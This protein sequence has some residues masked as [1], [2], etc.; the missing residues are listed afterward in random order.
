MLR[1][2]GWNKSLLAINLFL[3]SLAYA[4]VF[5]NLSYESSS[6]QFIKERS[7]YILGGDIMISSTSTPISQ[8]EL[9]SI[10]SLVKTEDS[11]SVEFLGNIRSKDSTTMSNVAAV[12]PN[13]PLLGTITLKDG[14]PYQWDSPDQIYLDKDIFNAL[15]VKVGDDVKIGE[16]QFK[17]AGE[18]LEDPGATRGTSFFA[19]RSYIP[20]NT[21]EQTGLITF[22]SQVS[23]RHF[24]ALSASTAEKTTALVENLKELSKNKSWEVRSAEDSINQIKRTLD[25]V[26]KYLSWLTLLMILLGFITGFYL[27]QVHLRS[28]ASRIA[29]LIQLG[30]PPR[31]V[32]V[33]YGLQIL[34]EH[35]VALIVAIGLVA[36]TQVL[37]IAPALTDLPIAFEFSLTGEALVITFGLALLM[38]F[39]FLVP[40]L[41]RVPQIQLKSLLDQSAPFIPEAAGFRTWLPYVFILLTFYALTGLFLRDYRLSLGWLGFLLLTLIVPILVFPFLLRKLG[42]KVSSITLKIPLLQLSRVRF[43]SSL[44]FVSL[45]QVLFILSLLPQ[46]K[47]SLEQELKQTAS[48][49][50]PDFFA[51]N[52]QEADLENIQ[53][54]FNSNSSGLKSLS[55]MILGRLMSV[56]SET[57]D[58]EDFSTRP[59]R[60]SYRA[61]NFPSE[62]VLE[63][64]E[65]LPAYTS[66]Q[67]PKGFLS[68]EKEYATRKNLKLG[69]SLKFLI[70]GLEI[71]AEIRQVR[72]VDWESFEPNFFMQFQDGFLNDFPKTW[73]GVIYDV[74]D[75]QKP[76]VIREALDEFSSMSIIDLSKTLEKLSEITETLAP[77]IQIAAQVQSGLTLL[78]LFLL[79]VYHQNSRSKEFVLF[80]LMGASPLKVKWMMMIENLVLAFTAGA[81]SIGLAL[82]SSRILTVEILETSYFLDLKTP[83]SY[84]GASL[85][86][87]AVVTWVSTTR[88]QNKK[89]QEVSLLAS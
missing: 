48:G 9:E 25:F 8:E 47:G 63:G 87:I 35:L 44:L 53:S 24:Y 7:R 12:T 83:L 56:N 54:F 61:Q 46:L 5:L 45:C 66:A 34:T 86:I 59:L 65:K 15:K 18:I 33:I 52:M 10:Q 68:I 3:L 30:C 23:Y 67:G 74:E 42:P 11:R 50:A 38:S 75:S 41:L 4:G 72:K 62:T 19:P 73:I 32:Q 40:Y 82:L 28:A 58:D 64:L 22:G 31:M 77:P 57:P 1:E 6:Q 21:A 39:L 51:I 76:E 60:L 78:I 70:G 80:Q 26:G 81:L 49:K 55:P 20:Y 27:S 43:A 2:W 85:L 29:L 14:L 13:Y 16:K 36:L 17:V 69:D 88:V 71:E 84:F 37:F 79:I 89:G